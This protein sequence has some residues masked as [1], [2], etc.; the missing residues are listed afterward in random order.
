MEQVRAELIAVLGEPLSRLERLSEQP[1]VHLYAMCDREGM[2]ST[3]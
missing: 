1:Y 3:W 2:R